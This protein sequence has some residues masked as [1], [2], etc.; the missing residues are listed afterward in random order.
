MPLPRVLKDLLNLPTAAFVET[1]V[2]VYIRRV[3]EALPGVTLREDS[4]GNLFATYR[5]KP[6]KARPLLL[7]AHT[8]HPGFVAERM[9]GPRTL[10]AEFRGG[11]YAEYLPGQRVR[12][13]SGGVW[14]RG[15]VERV[16]KT[17]AVYRLIQKV[18]MPEQALVRVSAE[19]APGSP[20]MWD[21]PD[22]RLRG[23]HVHARGCD[24]I[25]GCAGLL[26]LLIR[27]ARKRA[28]AE[29]TCLF[30]RAEEVGFVG[31]I[32]AARSRSI[33][34]GLPIV[35]IETSSA[36]AGAQIGGGPVLRV[37]DKASI[38]TPALTHFCGRV[39]MELAKRRKAFRFQRKLMDGGT[40]ESTAY[41]AYGYE[42]TGICLALGN[43]HNMDVDRTTIATEY[44]SLSDWKGMVD[45]FEALVMDERGYDGKSDAAE[46]R[47]D[48]EKRFK[49]WLPKLRG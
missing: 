1:E 34:P 8:D 2:L 43:Y 4:H 40:C 5:R 12:F 31:A 33:P 27:L 25:A 9:T 14:V 37:G 3:C 48:F 23:D 44:V 11:V 22:A 15:R 35:A 28:A 47:G 19:V 18:R 17:K 6:R 38:F 26:E 29:V 32:A 49:S 36:R 30:T 41:A 7:C 20:G 39:A 10:S 13:W 42:V 16:T 24:D 45:W 21:L 46:L